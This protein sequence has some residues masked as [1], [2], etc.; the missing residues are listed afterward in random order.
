MVLKNIDI[1]NFRNYTSLS[2]DLNPRLNIFVGENGMGKTNIL[3]AI[4]FLAITKSHR[5]SVDKKMIK[6]DD[7]LSKIKGFW[8]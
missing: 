5:N 3:E 4:Y 6:Q 8:E 1:N 2:L 7:F